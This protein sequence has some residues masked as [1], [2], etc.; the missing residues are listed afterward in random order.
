[1]KVEQAI[2]KNVAAYR[3]LRT[4]EEDRLKAL[5]HEIAELS[6]SVE[7]LRMKKNAAGTH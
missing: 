3:E 1:M 4:R 2:A 7:L 6:A 5:R